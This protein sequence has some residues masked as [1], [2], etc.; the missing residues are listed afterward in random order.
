[1]E[2]LKNKTAVITGGNS[3][4]GYATAQEMIKEGATVII[5]GRKQELVDKAAK[6]LGATGLVADQSS[7]AHI[8]A[9]VEKVALQFGK[10]DIL[11]LNA[12]TWTPM[13]LELVTEG[14]YDSFMDIN[15]K[16]AFFTLQKF[17]PL[18]KEGAAVTFM[19]ALSAFGGGDGSMAV[20]SASRAATNSFTRSIAVDLAARGIR[21]NAVCPG[22]VDTP[23]YE[24]S[25]LPE[26]V[27]SQVMDTLKEQIP[28][29][30]FGHAKDVA[31]L[32][33]FLSS[34]NASFITGS[35]YVIDGGLSRKPFI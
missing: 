11:F 31:K 27:L 18:L 35:E 6:G 8:E 17:I 1:M 29:K 2:S 5:T 28:L 13:P 16:G 7:L 4:I 3:G 12:G 34:D 30:R 9:L 19:S 26:A 24:K 33:A 32:V 20:Y 25:G 21:V 14:Y 22:P 23:V 10:I 15:L